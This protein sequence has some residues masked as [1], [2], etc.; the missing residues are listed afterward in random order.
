MDRKGIIAVAL[1]II[2]L[3]IW[4]QHYTDQMRQIAEAEKAKQKATE[5][6]VKAAETAA[7]PAGTAPTASATTPAAGATPAVPATP[8]APEQTREA[9]APSAKYFFTSRGGGVRRVILPEHLGQNEQPIELNQFESTPIG[10]VSEAP[11]QG[12]LQAWQ[13]GPETAGE[14]TFERTDSTLR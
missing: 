13:M 9:D 3:L 4:Q 1:A 6:A 7:N 2:T 11:G 14:V 10:A 5:E 8:E 12:T